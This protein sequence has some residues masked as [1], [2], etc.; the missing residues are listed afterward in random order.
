[1]SYHPG[2]FEVI[3]ALAEYGLCDVIAIAEMW[4]DR[5]YKTIVVSRSY[6]YTALAVLLPFYIFVAMVLP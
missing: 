5:C 4:G 1:M 3:I 2:S 6:A